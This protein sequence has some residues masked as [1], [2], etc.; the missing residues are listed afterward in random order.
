[1]DYSQII[2]GLLSGGAIVTIVQ[3]FLDRR[4]EIQSKESE[5]KEKRYKCI[6]LLMYAL[7]NP[8]E[9]KSINRIR[10]ELST[11]EDLEKEIKTELV[12][13]WLFAGDKTVKELENFMKNPCEESFAK[14]ILSMRKEL[15]NRRTKLEPKEF[16][17]NI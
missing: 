2:I 11:K 12:N 9:L 6:L 13:A 5:L 4:K 7:I 3:H 10:P 8:E 1:M 14:T 17:L 15:W 16:K